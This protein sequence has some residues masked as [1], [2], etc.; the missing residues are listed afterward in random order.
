M[1]KKIKINKRNKLDEKLISSVVSK[2]F[3]TIYKV[4]KSKEMIQMKKIF[5]I[6][7]CLLCILCL[8]GCKN[9]NY[10]KTDFKFTI[11][12]DKLTAKV[13]ETI[14]IKVVLK[15]VSGKNI[16]MQMCHT[17]FDTLEDMIKIGVFKDGEEHEFILDSKGGPRKKITFKKNKEIVKELSYKIEDLTDYE[18]L[19]A[20]CFYV[21]KDYNQKV[22]IFS[23][24]QK[25]SIEG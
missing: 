4:R 12:V 21:G 5:T 23:E 24:T 14:K 3:D 10:E 8:T 22:S 2:T 16:K 15:N 1:I 13:G 19:A 6:G 9:Y 18:I 7:I 25:I 17:D 20:I 11:S